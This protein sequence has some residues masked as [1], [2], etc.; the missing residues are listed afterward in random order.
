MPKKISVTALGLAHEG[1]NH[2][3]PGPPAVS[4]INP[5]TSPAGTPF[6]PAPFLYIARTAKL[7]PCTATRRTKYTTYRIAQVDACMDVENPANKPADPLKYVPPNGADLVTKFAV[8]IARITSCGHSH[9]VKAADKKLA[10]TGA[11][12][13]LNIPTDKQTVHQSRSKLLDGGG[14]VAAWND[15]AKNPC[16]I[17]ASGD[18]VALATGEVI[19]EAVD[20]MTPG[21]I[22][23]ELRRFYAS[24]RSAEVGPFGRGGWTHGYHQ[25]IERDGERLLLHD[26]NGRV[27]PLPPVPRRGAA[28]HKSRGLRI[29]RVQDRYEIRHRPSGLTRVFEPLSPGERAVL[30]RIHDDFGNAVALS[31]EGGRL[32]RIADTAGREITFAHDPEG[33]IARAEVHARGALQQAVAYAYHVDRELAA[34]TNAL[35]ETDTY[36]YDAQHRLVAKALRSGV[37]FRY[38]YDPDIQRCVRSTG[39]DRLQNVE[40]HY[41]TPAKVSVAGNPDPWEYEFDERG[42]VVSEKRVGS[43]STTR[44]AYD[45]DEL[46]ISI[47]TPAGEV[48]TFSYDEEARLVGVDGPGDRKV[49]FEYDGDR[50]AREIEGPRVTTFAWDHRGALA[51][52]T[53]PDGVTFAYDIDAWGRLARVSGPE[54]AIV[55]YAYDAEHNLAAMTDAR[56]ATTRLEHDAMGRVVAEIDA[57]GRAERTT[58]DAIGRPVRRA[59]RDGALIELT[60]DGGDNVIRSSD[61]AGLHN[62]FERCGTGRVARRTLP[63]GET[64]EM[65]YDILERLREIHNAKGEV[66]EYRYDRANRLVEEISFDGQSIRYAHSIAHEPI[67]I[68]YDDG[69]WIDL[70]RDARGRVIAEHNAHFRIEYERDALGRILRAAVDEHGG[71]VVTEIVWNDLDRVEKVVQD[72]LAITYTYDVM[73]RVASRTLPDGS[74]TKYFYD[75]AGGLVGLDH[76]GEKIAVQRD[77]AGLERRRYYHRSGLDVRIDYDVNDAPARIGAALLDPAGGAPVH[78]AERRYVYGP[79]AR[80]LESFDA[81]RG[82]RVYRRDLR[83]RILSCARAT[84]TEVYAYDAAG[85]VVW[86]GDRDPATPWGLRPGNVLVRTDR[87]RFTYDARRRRTTRTESDGSV[88]EY[89]WDCRNQ[90][91]EVKLP[92]GVRVLFKYDAF[93]RR[94]R[95]TIVTPDADPTKAPHVRR[96]DFLWDYNEL[97]AEIDS[98][99]GARSI[100]TARGTFLPMLQIEK[101]ESYAV[102]PD[103][104]GVPKELV[105]G[106]GQVA[107]RA[108]HTLWGRVLAEESPAGVRAPFSLL[109][110]YV[111][112][113]TGLAYVRHRYFDPETARWLS[114]DPLGFDGGPNLFGFDGMPTEEVDPLGLMTRAD[115]VQFMRQYRR[116]RI[117]AQRASDQA[118]SQIGTSHVV[119]SVDSRGNRGQSGQTLRAG[120]GRNH[121]PE[122]YLHAEE[123]VILQGGSGRAVGAGIPHCANCTNDIITSRNVTTTRINPSWDP[124]PWVRP[125]GGWR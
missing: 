16:V 74:V 60:Y 63:D 54:G 18:P 6:T 103:A 123:Q 61:G 72:G 111:D 34:V 3:A 11:D 92:S 53:G 79:H 1:S 93:G 80:L 70:E 12:V 122:D 105:S 101:G 125:D 50:L 97:A 102:V 8:G 42:N 115:F 117:Q 73:G 65:A 5:P 110:H 4:G 107:W 13:I 98:E 94:V 109:G 21:T 59:M 112:E 56:G 95:K 86:A 25:W 43:G 119:Y 55:S 38:T 88:T 46:L 27:V 96:V 108:D 68:D 57:L 90:L 51:R 31:Y 78:V 47:T 49:T 29:A 89:L 41:E 45:A 99:R 76:G 114:R 48:V 23:V 100:V 39:P 44:Y 120:T 124:E 32:A 113:E 87:A 20:L 85:S 37:V 82:R 118:Q 35:G 7:I 62:G 36:S 71:P 83:G 17:R 22:D 28:L 75:P 121:R 14:L 58:Y 104:M 9:D 77:A 106:R 116:Q 67:R 24:G 2:A 33:R 91:R 84:G 15:A 30:T 69:T 10:V 40:L 52:V 19:D 26:E 66:Y 64:W 81:D